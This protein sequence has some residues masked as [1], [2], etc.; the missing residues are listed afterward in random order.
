MRRIRYP[1]YNRCT[2]CRIQPPVPGPAEVRTQNQQPASRLQSPQP[3]DVWPQVPTPTKMSLKSVCG[4]DADSFVEWILRGPV[5]RRSA[6][7]AIERQRPVTESPGGRHRVG[8]SVGYETMTSGD[9]DLPNPPVRTRN[10]LPSRGRRWTVVR[11]SD[12]IFEVREGQQVVM[13]GN[14]SECSDWIDRQ[15]QLRPH[16]ST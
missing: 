3:R 9:D 2:E 16:R 5:D 10:D 8:S 1:R 14:L 11:Q 6:M 4:F 15:E 12:A 13:T 7:T